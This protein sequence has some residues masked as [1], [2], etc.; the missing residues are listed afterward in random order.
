MKFALIRF[1][2]AELVTFSLRCD[3]IVEASFNMRMKCEICRYLYEYNA[4]QTFRQ[5]LT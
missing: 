3:S 4:E 1:S 5:R 2:K